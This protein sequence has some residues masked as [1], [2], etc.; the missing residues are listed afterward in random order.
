MPIISPPI[1][2]GP[3]DK[4]GFVYP[5]PDVEPVID[6]SDATDPIIAAQIAQA[7]NQG[8]ALKAAALPDLPAEPDGPPLQ[9]V[10]VDQTFVDQNLVEADPDAVTV[11]REPF[12]G[13]MSFPAV[14]VG[15]A[16]FEAA[17]DVDIAVNELLG[18]QPDQTISARLGQGESEGELLAG[19]AA[20]PLNLIDPGHTQASLAH[21]CCSGNRL[22][23][24]DRI[25]A[26]LYDR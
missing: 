24:T 18:G 3:P 10:P 25:E 8:P 12:G 23:L 9:G 21:Y 4:P 6:L 2:T 19:L 13:A 15:D 20:V 17:R 11:H 7:R 16:V 26:E 5:T 22:P 1:D 14:G